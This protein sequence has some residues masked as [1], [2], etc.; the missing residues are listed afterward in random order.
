MSLQEQKTQGSVD[1]RNEK[2]GAISKKKTF[3]FTKI[4]FE[5][6]KNGFLNIAKEDLEADLRKKIY[7]P[8]HRHSVEAS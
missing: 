8:T 6:E 7:Q 1:K 3:K 5:G 4:L 2:L